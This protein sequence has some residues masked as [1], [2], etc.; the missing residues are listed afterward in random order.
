[1]QQNTPPEELTGNL[2]VGQPKTEAA[3][4][5]AVVKSFEHVLRGTDIGRGWK[6]LV[7]LNQKDGYDCPSCA[8]PD[9]DGH[10]SAVAE[11]CENG[12]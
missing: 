12:A 3:G 6:A 1:M 4:L 9:P 5:T 2:N 10:R 8:W 7:N 11:Y